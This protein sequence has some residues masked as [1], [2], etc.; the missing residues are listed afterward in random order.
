VPRDRDCENCQIQMTSS[1]SEA[2][3]YRR[4][5]VSTPTSG[6]PDSEVVTG[7]RLRG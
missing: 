3:T 4:L 7:A 5:G 1:Q 6:N 2:A